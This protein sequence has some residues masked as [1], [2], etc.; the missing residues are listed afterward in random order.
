MIAQRQG[1]KSPDEIRDLIGNLTGL[2]SLP[3]V[4]PELLALLKDSDVSSR[5]LAQIIKKDP[6]LSLK[7][8]GIVNSSSYSFRDPVTTIDLAITLMGSREINQVALGFAL[9][10]T[11][12]HVEDAELNFY[13][14]WQHSTACAHMASLLEKNLNLSIR[15]GA[16]TAA[17]V[18][19][20]GKLALYLLEDEPYRGA[21]RLA[22]EQNCSIFEMEE[23]LLGVTHTQ[24]GDWLAAAWGLPESIRQV[25]AWHHD[26]QKCSDEDTRILTSLIH[27]ANMM[28]SLR[29]F[30][31]GS[32]LLRF[33]PS[34]DYGWNKLMSVSKPDGVIDFERMML[35][36]EDEIEV[37]QEMTKLT[38]Q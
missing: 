15:G 1:V 25:I 33:S 38:L 27:V 16:F 2:P 29:A 4:V 24:A 7:I 26:P 10:R 37:I 11:F 3:A 18:H 8:L 32:G 17:L 13:R 22:A 6:G 35:G 31:F 34:D 5:E 21:C 20:V 23:E 19:D 9:V 28:T 12:K 36:I 14:F 30:D